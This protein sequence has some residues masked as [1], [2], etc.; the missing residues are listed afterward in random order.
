MYPPARQDVFRVFV[1]W[2]CRGGGLFAG[3]S[4]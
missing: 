3:R 1:W 4:L 2:I